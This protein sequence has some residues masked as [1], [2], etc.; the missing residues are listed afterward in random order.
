MVKVT[1]QLPVVRRPGRPPS[2][3]TREATRRRILDAALELFSE[4]GYHNTSM[5]D[6]V[7]AAG[8]SKG[9]VYFH[10]PSKD[11]M[12][13]AL[14]DECADALF[15][16]SLAAAIAEDDTLNRLAAGVRA[17]IQGCWELRSARVVFGETIGMNPLLDRKREETMTRFQELISEALNVAVAEEAI[18]PVNT[19][20]LARA[21]VG[22]FAELGMEVVRSK[23]PEE[24]EEVAD[25]LVD[26]LC[27]MALSASVSKGVFAR[28]AR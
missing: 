19:R 12:F 22:A 24:V 1:V 7:R 15:H 13:S 18:P 28:A 10:F 6:V 20:I 2:A 5:D 17:F 26:V 25:V 11:A 23:S 14:Y 27:A 21:M 9:G 16:R 8:L 3:V 4:R